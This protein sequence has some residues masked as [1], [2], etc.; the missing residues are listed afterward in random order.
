[1]RFEP[2]FTAKIEQCG[3][4][5]LLDHSAMSVTSYNEKS[6]QSLRLHGNQLTFFSITQSLDDPNNER[7]GIIDIDVS[8]LN[9]TAKYLYSSSSDKATLAILFDGN[10]PMKFARKEDP[11]MTSSTCWGMSIDFANHADAKKFLSA[12]TQTVIPLHVIN[13]PGT[14]AY[15]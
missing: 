11:M 7:F 14:E 1:M 10:Y 6:L 5:E 13:I 15:L 8:K 9:G 2:N 3:G 4:L 12:F